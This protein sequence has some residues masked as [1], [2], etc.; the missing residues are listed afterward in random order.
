MTHF[1]AEIM[2]KYILSITCTLAF[3]NIQ[4][5][6]LQNTAWKTY[7]APASDTLTVIS[8]TDSFF[9]NSSTGL[10]G[11]TALYKEMNDTVL[12]RDLSGAQSCVN[13]DTG[14]YRFS[15]VNDTLTFTYLADSCITRKVFL[16]GAV[17]WRINLP[18]GNKLLQA[19][20]DEFN[21]YPN[22]NKGFFQLSVA[23]SIDQQ[24]YVEIIDII[25]QVVDGW[26]YMIRTGKQ[27]I[28]LN[29]KLQSGQYFLKINGVEL[30]QVERFIVE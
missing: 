2:L 29:A 14:W 27:D 15:I 7:S 3:L 20:N 10:N 25:G 9:V 26:E 11:V 5:Q 6:S 30:N 13:P 8:K 16:E 12:I 4:S 19:F 28:S 1:K 22:P 18:T 21:I 23:T 17:L 24:V